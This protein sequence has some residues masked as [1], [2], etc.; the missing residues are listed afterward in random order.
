MASQNASTA[1]QAMGYAIQVVTDASVMIT[2][3]ALVV[4]TM[5]HHLGRDEDVAASLV[6]PR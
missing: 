2:T 5:S 6:M 4:G 3:L 1:A